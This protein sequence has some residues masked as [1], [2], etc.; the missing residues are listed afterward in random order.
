V[1]KVYR[2]YAQLRIFWQQRG[3]VAALVE[4]AKANDMARFFE[5]ADQREWDHI[6]TKTLS[7]KCPDATDPGGFEA[8]QALQFSVGITRTR[9]GERFRTI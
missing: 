8:Y 5:L 1:L 4:P 2:Q 6:K 7:I 3:D 9:R